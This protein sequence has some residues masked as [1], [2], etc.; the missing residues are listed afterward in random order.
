MSDK[1]RQVKLGAI[2]SYLLIIINALYSVVLTPYIISIVGEFDYGVYKSVAAVIA[3]MMVL[4]LGVGGTVQRY[5]AKF[6]AYNEE[7]KIPNFM[8]LSFFVALIIVGIMGIAVLL[9]HNLIPLLYGKTFSCSQIELAK[10]IFAISSFGLLIHVI[11]NVVNGF[12]TGYNDF[13][14]GNGIRLASI[15]LRIVLLIILLRIYKSVLVIV[16]I[17]TALSVFFL[18][19]EY[20]YARKKLG[21]K[22]KYE[23]WDKSLFAE[24][25]KY[26]ALMFL[27]SLAGQFFNN[28]DSIVIGSIDGPA[29]VTVYSIALM[30]FTMFQ[31]LSAGIA[32]VM[33]PTVTDV[34]S[35]A[36]GGKKIINVVISA[37]RMQFLLL[38]AALSGFIII[39]KDFINVWMGAGYED[40]YMIALILLVPS[41]FELCI[42]VCHSILRANNKL[43]FRTGVVVVSAITNAILTIIF[44]KTWSYIG[45][46]VATAISYTIFSLIVMNFYYSK[47]FHLPMKSI[48]REIVKGILPCNII[49]SLVLWIVSKYFYGSWIAVFICI[50]IFCLVYGICLLLFGLKKEEKVQMPLLGKFFRK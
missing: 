7:Y 3:A 44:V 39:G 23:C 16:I 38:G 31:N 11:E 24:A 28:V 25:G 21:L 35:Q 1:N 37:G 40:V 8:S 46:A 9:G 22:I 12:I 49:A 41:M 19:V 36:D 50:F 43:G 4:D 29:F 47:S 10:V 17:T 13:V 18:L 20:V 48:Y 15:I 2:F 14:F 26:T 6:R 32:G 42:N 5:I 34:L 27:T 45:A 30:L 33:L